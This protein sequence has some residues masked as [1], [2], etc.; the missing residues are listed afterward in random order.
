[1]SDQANGY[2]GPERRARTPAERKADQRDR[3]RASTFV[4]DESPLVQALLDQ[5]ADLRRRLDLSEERHLERD[6][7]DTK[8]DSF[9]VTKVVTIVTEAVSRSLAGL[10]RADTFSSSLSLSGEEIKNKQDGELQDLKGKT[11]VPVGYLATGIAVPGK[12]GDERD[13]TN[14]HDVTKRDVTN[15]GPVVAILDSSE[16]QSETR[17][18]A[19]GPPLLGSL[20]Q[21]EIDSRRA[22]QLKRLEELET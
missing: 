21:A 9:D 19:L 14:G 20:T 2:T 22:A 18:R 15:D 16:Q 1:M 7:R 6:I 3:R 10:A 13:V 11:R 8:R 4:G 17:R 5:I 12:L